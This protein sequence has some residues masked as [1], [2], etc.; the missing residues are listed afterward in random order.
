[1]PSLGQ[2]PSVV[3]SHRGRHI[4]FI[5]AGLVTFIVLAG[6]TY[7]SVATALERRQ[8]PYPGRLIDVGDHQLHLH[9]VGEGTPTVVLEAPAAGVSTG[10]AWV[11]DDLART[12]RVCS[13]DRAGLGWS[14]MG[15][16][17]Y[18]AASVPEELAMLLEGAGERGP[19]VIA[20]HEVGASFARMFAS[21]FRHDT[22]ALVLVDDP[23]ASPSSAPPRVPRLVSAWPWLARIGVLRATRALSRHAS[24]LAGDSGAATRAFLNRPDH[25]T[26]GVLEIAR[27]MDTANA[28][29]A[30]PLD[31]ALPVTQITVNPEAP[32]TLLDSA[33]RARE[34]TRAIRQTVTRIRR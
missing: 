10:W 18:R 24:G 22:A 28:A 29:A 12:T 25:L 20:G 14:E 2:A 1:M 32:P 34:V 15:D 4:V 9:C 33:D 8:F 26:R 16:G 13:Y 6:V 21:R 19:F 17:G 27:L 3:V 31:P 30:E 11:Q 7:Q 23:S 5:V